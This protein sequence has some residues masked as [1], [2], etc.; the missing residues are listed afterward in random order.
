MM[1][2]ATVA[3]SKADDVPDIFV[4]IDDNGYAYIK[5]VDLLGKVEDDREWIALPVRKVPELI[6]ALLKIKL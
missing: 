2:V 3:M 5:Q 1:T 6:A 4:D